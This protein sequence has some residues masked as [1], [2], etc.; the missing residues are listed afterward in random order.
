MLM[1]FLKASAKKALILYLTDNNSIWGGHTSK[2]MFYLLEPAEKECDDMP[3][4]KQYPY[5]TNAEE[6]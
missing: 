1:I 5:M 4:R 3:W 2:K 6:Y